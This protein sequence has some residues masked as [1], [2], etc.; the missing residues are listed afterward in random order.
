MLASKIFQTN[1]NPTI[2]SHIKF[3]PYFPKKAMI[4]SKPNTFEIHPCYDYPLQYQLFPKLGVK[5]TDFTMPLCTKPRRFYP[6]PFSWLPNYL[7]T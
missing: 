4:Y 6:T 3:I 7:L 1:E 5:Y 2:N